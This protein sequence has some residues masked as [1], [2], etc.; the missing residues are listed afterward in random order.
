MDNSEQLSKDDELKRLRLSILSSVTPLIDSEG[1]E[2]EERL[3]IIFQLA[4]NN[5]SIDLYKKAYGLIGALSD[6]ESKLH[7][8]MELLG[9]IEF[10]IDNESDATDTI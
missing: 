4:Q 9:Y 10:E 5:S 6:G 2:P 1:L 3:R 8:Y 7:F